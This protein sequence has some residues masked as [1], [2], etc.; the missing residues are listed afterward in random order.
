MNADWG[1]VYAAD[2]V[3][4]K[5]SIFMRTWD[6]VVDAH[7]PVVQ[8]TL[9]RPACPWLRNEEV[10]EVMGERDAARR[11]WAASRSIADR[12]C[13]K[14]LRNL[15][16][17][18]LSRARRS[19]LTESLHCDARQFWS[20][21]KQ[22]GA[23]FSATGS[24]NAPQPDQDALCPDRLNEHFAGVGAR[25]AAE[26]SRAARDVGACDSGPRPYRVCASAFAPRCITMPDS[27]VELYRYTLVVVAT[28]PTFGK[29][30]ITPMA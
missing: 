25:V 7:C 29:F 13:Y 19:H 24:R 16:K 27:W 23:D 15:S 1:P 17:L 2:N 12:N 3:N 4:S 9:R 11:A 14:R 28:T 21:L 8:K 5:L 18:V 30:S 20:R 6:A 22:F 10:R 26:A